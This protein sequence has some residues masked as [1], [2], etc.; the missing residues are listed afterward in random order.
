M[1]KSRKRKIRRN[2]SGNREEKTT[3]SQAAVKQ[4]SGRVDQYI[5][6]I[7]IDFLCSK[8]VIRFEHDSLCSH[9]HS[10]FN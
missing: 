8:K 7:V 10:F 5:I 3:I 9:Q 2:Y 1:D 4:R 6:V